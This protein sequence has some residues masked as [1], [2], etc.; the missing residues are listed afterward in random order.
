MF[1]VLGSNSDFLII[2]SFAAVISGVISLI[3]LILV[4][5]LSVRLGRLKKNYKQMMNGV[6]IPNLEE[7]IIHL[8]NKVTQQEAAVEQNM[9]NF[10]EIRTYLKTMKSKLGVYRY[11]AFADQGS[12]LS[13]SIALLDEQQDGVVLTGL[14][15]RDESYMYA[16]PIVRGESKYALTPEEKEAISRSLKSDY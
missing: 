10:E 4:I 8:Q 16:K 1:E 2:L 3:S 6:N 12:D 14:H 11:N 13:F 7:V 5:S 15:S 9:R